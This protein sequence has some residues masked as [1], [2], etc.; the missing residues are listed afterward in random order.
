MAGRLAFSELI[1]SNLTSANMCLVLFSNLH[2]EEDVVLW[3]HAEA[4][5]DGTELR[6]N[7]F[8]HDICSARGGRE[9]S[10]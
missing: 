1:Y 4:P 7:I 10:S 2:A 9:K 3:T 6:A 5:S 8:A